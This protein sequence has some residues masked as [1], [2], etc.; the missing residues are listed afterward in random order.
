MPSEFC[1]AL[2]LD[3]YAKI[4]GERDHIKDA[5]IDTIDRFEELIRIAFPRTQ[6]RDKIIGDRPA[7]MKQQD[8]HCSSSGNQGLVLFQA[9]KPL[10]VPSVDHCH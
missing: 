5:F 4:P 1:K 2:I 10:E 7:S 6:G 9:L 3:V 8:A